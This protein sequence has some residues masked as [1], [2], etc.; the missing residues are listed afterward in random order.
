MGPIPPSPRRRSLGLTVLIGLLVA[1]PLAAVGAPPGL[2]P[3]GPAAAPSAVAP[4]A[5]EAS[6]VSTN[7]SWVSLTPS[8]GP[9]PLLRASAAMTYDA[10]DGYTLLFG[11]CNRHLCPL[12]DT[13]KY[14]DGLWTNLTSSLAVAPP[15]RQGAALAFDPLD[16]YVL[17][18]GGVGA[19]NVTLNDTWQY[20]GGTWT[21]IPTAAGA[22]PSAR[23]FAQATFVPAVNAVVLFGGR[24]ASGSVLS[25]TWTFAHGAWADESGALALAPPARAAAVFSYDPTDG[26]AVLFGGSGACGTYCGDTWSYDARGW[27]DL[28]GSLPTAPGARTNS[29][30]SYDPTRSVLLLY[31]GWNGASMSDTWTFTNGTWRSLTADLSASPGARYGSASTYDS[32]DGYLL[33]YGGV[34]AGGGR[35]STWGL[36]SPLSTALT[37]R[38]SPLAPGQAGT[39]SAN[40]TGGLGP[41]NI[42]WQFGD[43]TPAAQGAV[44]SHTFA[45]AGSYTVQVT[46]TDAAADTLTAE[47]PVTVRL[48]PLNVTIHPSVTSGTIGQPLQFTAVVSGGVAPFTYAWSAP[49]GICGTTHGPTLNCTPTAGG[50]LQVGVT[51]VD[52]TGQ[53]IGVGLSV[54][55]PGTG[56]T[57]SVPVGGSPAATSGRT[58]DWVILLPLAVALAGALGIGLVMYRAGRRR[59]KALLA[60]R[61]HCYAVPAWSETPAD[62]NAIPPAESP[63]DATHRD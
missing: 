42:S 7:A 27:A 5:L 12:G 10:A 53:T 63:A 29:T 59:A 35:T 60:T 62:F 1:V 33:L 28:T 38:S 52:S 18:F 55:V 40:V 48:T 57:G 39:F 50:T 30:L 31:G 16:G 58:N 24:S 4:P 9:S 2:A 47:T 20:V 26:Y 46:V 34:I 3:A 36:L 15:A 56:A 51:V 43:G 61:P 37:A 13:W 49:A 19:N 6:T 44:V 32:L 41:F 21:Q 8:V 17:M 22:A 45:A 25:D 11:G 54:A 23:S 14:Q